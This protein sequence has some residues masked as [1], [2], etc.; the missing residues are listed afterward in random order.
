MLFRRR[1][2]ASGLAFL[3]LSSFA[4]A[5]GES[6]PPAFGP[7][8]TRRE[9][10]T[11]TQFEGLSV[12]TAGEV[13]TALKK[14][15]GTL[16]WSLYFR[17]P[18]T[19][20]FPSRPQMALNLGGLIADGYIAVEA[21]NPQQVKNIGKDIVTLAKPLGVQQELINRGKSLND[22]AEQ[23]KWEVLKEE[24][25]ATQS[26][27]KSAMAENKDQNLVTFVTIGAWVRGAEVMSG[28]IAQHYTEAGA[29][30][31]RQPA[32][33]RYLSAQ[34]SAMGDK[35]RDDPVVG[36]TR[37]TLREIDAAVSFPRGSTPTIEEV[38]RL[39]A[40]ASELTRAISSKPAK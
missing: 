4:G 38:K 7:P 25:E 8:L 27:M 36:K 9:L 30:L 24:L 37:S 35:L 18:I 5:Q 39:H 23:G 3:C 40:L 34:L 28:H 1:S 16:D 22:F 26:G 10:A 33:V 2:V 17:P 11:A 14:Q 12:P 13:M 29:R 6:A 15:G 32:I 21:Q 19:M 31:L 20:N